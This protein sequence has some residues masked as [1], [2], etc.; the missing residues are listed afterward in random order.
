MLAVALLFEAPVAGEGARRGADARAAVEEAER[1]TNDA[2][3]LSEAKRYDEAVRLA[4]RAVA[5]REEGLGSNDP[6]VGVSLNNLGWLLGQ[7]GDYAAAEPIQRRAIALLEKAHD[8]RA[9]LAVRNLALTLFRKGDRAAAEPLYRRVLATFERER[10]A[11]APEVA[12]SLSDLA[13]VVEDRGDLAAG[14]SLRRRALAIREKVL[15]PRH[16]DTIAAV[17]DLAYLLTLRGDDAAAAVLYRRALAAR[18]ATLGPDHRDV[19]DTLTGLARAL[20]HELDFAGAEAALRRA[21]A[22]ERKQAG[23]DS[24]DVADVLSDLSDLYELKGALPEAEALERGALEIRERRLGANDPA[25]ATSLSHVAML[26]RD[27]GDGADGEPLQR[28]AV[29]IWQKSAAPDDESLAAGLNGLALMMADRDDFDGAEAATLRAIA[30]FEKAR[31]PDQPDVAMFLR[32]LGDTLLRRGDGDAA[33]RTLR[34]AKAI[35]DKAAGPHDARTVAVDMDLG[36]LMRARG[37]KVEAARLLRE[38]LSATERLRGPDHPN[39]ARILSSLGWVLLDEDDMAGVE[40]AFRRALAIREK[41]I[42]PD[43]PETARSATNLA[44]IHSFDRPGE[45]EALLRRALAIY[46]KAMGPQSELVEGAL[47][48]LASQLI[49]EG[50]TKEALSLLERASAIREPFVASVLGGGSTRQKEA[51]FTTQDGRAEMLSSILVTHAPRDP[52]A[53]R[54]ALTE[55]LR[56]KGRAL[57]SSMESSLAEQA[58]EDPADAAKLRRLSGLR[59][60]LATESLRRPLEEG[61]VAEHRA[62]L[63]R[64]RTHIEELERDLGNQYRAAVARPEAA[65][66]EAV[67]ARLAPGSALVELL[68]YEQVDQWTRETPQ[69]PDDKNDWHYIAFVLAADAKPAWVDLG[70]GEAIDRLALEARRQLAHA[71]PRYSETGRAL[72]AKVMQ[73]IRALLG[74]AHDVYVSPDGALSLVPL[75]ALIDERG[76]FLVSRYRFTW[77]TSGRELL[78]LG[79]PEAARSGPVIVAGPDYARAVLRTTASDGQRTSSA[80]SPELAAPRF[81]SLPG[82]TREGRELAQVVSGA[83]LVTAGAATETFVKQLEGPS[84]LH[85]ATHGFFFDAAPQ[86]AA[87]GRLGPGRGAQVVDDVALRQEN[88]EDPLLRSGLALAGANTGHGG[89][90]DGILTALEVS[91]LHLRGTKLVVLSACDTGIGKVTDGGGVYGLRSSFRLAGAQ[92]EV[93]SLWKV[94][95]D[96]TRLLMRDY[97][98]RLA[99]GGGRSDALR[100]AQLAMLAGAATANPYYW[101]AWIASGDERS[102]D[103]GPPAAVRIAD[104]GVASARPGSR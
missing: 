86:A 68:H 21:L 53:L 48:D 50:R 88:G 61:A 54:L 103:G 73:P 41:T 83:R 1:L 96:A 49:V 32:S 28:R 9:T 80:R 93:M 14:E 8:P 26:M 44:L 25:V 62:A 94:D 92:S 85:I 36:E 40:R 18:E 3:R 16:A 35:C 42:G 56:W 55:V 84:I 76:R 64:L 74:D 4:R 38:A 22:I 23:A 78:R 39:V 52:R 98:R 46:E 67:A 63:D 89:S 29:E 82:A 17:N 27:L 34:R 58:I 37:N 30:L 13:D 75:A 95:D 102:L 87:R 5:L 59:A 6:E 101:A 20:E 90:D 71:D 2:L 79:A 72:D 99:A 91:G 43:A 66:I 100:E 57:E 15:G 70:D 12:T 51:I 24:T 10:G 31:G 104:G 77:L 45:A 81:A 65:T 7:Q 47:E 97:Y 60:A 69:E 19:A 11:E 33:E